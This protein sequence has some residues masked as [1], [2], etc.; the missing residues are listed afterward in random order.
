MTTSKTMGFLEGLMDGPLTL[1]GLLTAVREGEGWSQT[2][3]AARLGV[4][5]QHLSA[6][7]KGRKVVS[8]ERAALWAAALGYGQEQFV[9]LAL[10]Q[11][12]E[13]AGLAF[14]VALTPSVPAKIRARRRGPRKAT[15]A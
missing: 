3:M 2:D 1:A 12:L 4:S 6:V 7:E 5:K 14:H 8:P 10:Q 11:Q 13:T 9:R 15:A